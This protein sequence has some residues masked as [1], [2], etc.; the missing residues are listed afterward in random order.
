MMKYWK[1]LRGFKR[2]A[3]AV[4]MAAYVVLEMSGVQI[5]EDLKSNIGLIG[6]IIFGI[7]W[8][9][10]GGAILSEKIGGKK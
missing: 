4:V 5:P 9:D 6:S 10:R 8:L 7:G 2:Q 3:G 1:F